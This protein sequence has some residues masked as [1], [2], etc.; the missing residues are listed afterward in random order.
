MKPVDLPLAPKN[1]S[2]NTSLLINRFSDIRSTKTKIESGKGLSKS[3]RTRKPRLIEIPR[4]IA[5]VRI[6]RN[7]LG[8]DT[9]SYVQVG[10]TIAVTKTAPSEITLISQSDFEAMGKH[11]QF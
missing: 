7:C 1:F 9:G 3:F 5:A 6:S 2:A 4:E 11:Y 8:E 10:R